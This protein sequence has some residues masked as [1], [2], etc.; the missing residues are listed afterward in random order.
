MEV[1]NE[2][3]LSGNVGADRVF[4]PFP[5]VIDPLNL[6]G[7][8]LVELGYGLSREYWNGAI[9]PYGYDLLWP[10]LT[11]G[12]ELVTLCREFNGCV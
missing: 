7:V 4:V 12:R 11:S 6:S 5:I 10:T 1:V 3:F 2:L 9:S 8:A